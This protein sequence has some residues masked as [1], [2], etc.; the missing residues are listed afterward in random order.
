MSW[1]SYSLYA[2]IVGVGGIVLIIRLRRR[3]VKEE[4]L[5]RD[6]LEGRHRFDAI[7]TS[8]P[9]DDPSKAARA[10]GLASIASRFSGMRKAILPAVT[11][12]LMALLTVPLLGEMPAAIVS[13]LAAVVAVVAGIAAKPLLE[14]LFAGVVIS[15][16][17]PI[18]IGDTVMMDGN[19]GTVED[20]SFTHT[21]VK[22]W[23][24]RR[25]MVPNSKMIQKE[26]VNYSLIDTYQWAYVEFW[27]APDVDVERVREL[28][29]ES[30][31][32]SSY[33][34]AYEDPS[35]WVMEMAKEGVRCWVAAWANTPSSAWQLTH[36]IRTN[37]LRAFRA[38]GIAT[39][40]FRL[41][42]LERP[43]ETGNRAG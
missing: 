5:R 4:E 20:I 35:F 18:R 32:Q 26:F 11:I 1:Q 22:T 34:A 30:A 2:A 3:L 10:R 7:R 25:Y 21:T 17:Q 6:R 27:V 40:S 42:E 39:H 29:I 38:E 12:L 19:F 9:L 14:N 23:D 24:W 41:Q 31:R 37:M 33:F 28:A 36:D 8:S 16:S 15:M 43:R 13:F